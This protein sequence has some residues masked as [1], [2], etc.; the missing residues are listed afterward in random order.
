MS[1]IAEAVDVAEQRTPGS[2]ILQRGL[3]PSEPI[4]ARLIGAGKRC[5]NAVA[6]A[7]LPLRYRLDRDVPGRRRKSRQSPLMSGPKDIDG[8]IDQRASD[9]TTVCQAADGRPNLD[10][11]S[12]DFSNVFE[13]SAVSPVHFRPTTSLRG[14]RDASQNQDSRSIAQ[15]GI[16]E[17][18][19]S[20]D[21][22]TV[23]N[24]ASAS[25]ANRSSR[26]RTDQPAG[27]FRRV[28]RAH[29]SAPNRRVPNRGRVAEAVQS[30]RSEVSG[31]SR[32]HL[33]RWHVLPG[34]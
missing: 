29:R 33:Y 25:R 24:R 18:M 16:I 20:R 22:T 11:R 4:S 34:P 12:S 2:E 30:R 23:A 3:Q 31:I 15:S 19:A 26:Y 10:I 14:G 8:K 17:M 13:S 9:G 1:L 28:P 5:R 7:T 32:H 27:W 6:Q 21:C